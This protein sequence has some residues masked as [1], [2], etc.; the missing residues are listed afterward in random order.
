MAVPDDI[1]SCVVLTRPGAPTDTHFATLIDARGWRPVVLEDPALA[2]A[3]LCLL[4]RM[5]AVGRRTGTA[6]ELALVIRADDPRPLDELIDAVTRYVPCAE[7]WTYRSDDLESLVARAAAPS[8]TV[9]AT[10]ELEPH[11]DGD[12]GDVTAPGGPPQITEQELAMLFENDRDG[13]SGP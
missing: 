12:D 5:H 2:M 6:P 1:A 11:P 13:A 9:D 4:E 7:V 10:I 8:P 3:E